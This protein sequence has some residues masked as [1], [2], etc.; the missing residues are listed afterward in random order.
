MQKRD[1]IISSILFLMFCFF[2]LSVFAIVSDE[3]KISTNISTSPTMEE[4]E[5]MDKELSE[6]K[7]AT[8]PQRKELITKLIDIIKEDKFKAT[9][10]YAA[11][12][13]LG[14]I[15]ASEAID[16]LLDKADYSSNTRIFVITT[17][18]KENA[19]Q[20]PAVKALINIHPPYESIIKR[21]TDTNNQVGSWCYIA[22]LLGTEGEDVCRYIIENAIEKESNEDKLSR[23]ESALKMLNKDFPIE[24]KEN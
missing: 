6:L 4:Y 2:G 9:G 8:I 13:I 5:Q 3:S 12:D 14:Q 21:L 22:I 1:I 18:P 23:L 20:Y 7:E 10:T 24:K 11:M 16:I 17:N 19:R 15:R